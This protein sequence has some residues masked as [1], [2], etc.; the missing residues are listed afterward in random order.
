MPQQNSDTISVMIVDDHK[1]VRDG[2]RMIVESRPGMRVVGEAGAKDEALAAIEKES[3]DIVLLDLDLKNDSG[4]DILPEI[5]NMNKGVRVLIL[6]GVRDP[7]VH[8]QCVRLGA[9]GLVQKELA[10]DTLI[11]AIEKV[12]AG[13]IWFDR[14]M[15]SSLLNEVL[16]QKNG[17]RDDPEAAKIATLTEREREV[18]GLVCQGLKNKQVAERL[19]ISDT[20]VRHHLTSIF[21]K[22]DVSDRLELVIYSYRFGLAEPPK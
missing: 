12:H 16:N 11:K 21:S 6:T 4:L 19:F 9:R 17:K 1:M 18:I 10:S 20:T 8:Q 13:E 3:P 14:N 5:K 15:M 7:E 2:I 22:L